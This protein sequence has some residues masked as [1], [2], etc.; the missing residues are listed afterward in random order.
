M[1]LSRTAAPGDRLPELAEVVT[2]AATLEA[3]TTE[4]LRRSRQLA[5]RQ[6]AWLRRDPR[7]VWVDAS[8]EDLVEYF[9]GLLD[10][11]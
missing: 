2:G 4:I 3:A 7:I 8:R 5:R 1:K 9:A 11:E 6:M 10:A